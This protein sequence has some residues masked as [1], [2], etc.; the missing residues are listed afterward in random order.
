MS[1]LYRAVQ[2]QVFSRPDSL[3]RM[4]AQFKD[5]GLG[6]TFRYQ[7]H[8]KG[9]TVTITRTSIKRPGTGKIWGIYTRGAGTAS[10][11]QGA[12]D[13]RK[14]RKRVRERPPHHGPDTNLTSILKKKW[15]YIPQDA[16]P[17]TSAR[18]AT[19]FTR[20]DYKF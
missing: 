20:R 1:A 9:T 10:E 2:G 18:S 17:D 16:P 8:P 7:N 3:L 5:N 12:W 13:G 11:V 14:A 19:A 4:A 6:R 15:M